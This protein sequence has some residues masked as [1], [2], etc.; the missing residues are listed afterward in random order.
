MWKNFWEN[1]KK[2][3]EQ[4][5]ESSK[6]LSKYQSEKNKDILAKPRWTKLS[7]NWKTLVKIRK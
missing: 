5:M 3:L 7:E 2:Q 4:Y 6:T 1:S